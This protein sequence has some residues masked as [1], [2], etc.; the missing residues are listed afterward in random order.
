MAK[1]RF[2]ATTEDVDDLLTRILTTARTLERDVREG[3]DQIGDDAEL[4]FA[5]HALKRTGRMARGIKA[6]RAGNMVLV[7][8]KAVDPDSGYDYVA[9]TRFGHRGRIVVKN[10]RALRFMMKGRVMFRHSTA[11]FHPTGDWANDALPQ[12]FEAAD[13]VAKRLGFEIIARFV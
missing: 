10:A 1:S 13:A 11:G 9:V 2:T 5:G 3:V 4:I 7:E 12:V 8:A 6:R